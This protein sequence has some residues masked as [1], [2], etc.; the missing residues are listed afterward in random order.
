VLM[1]S[2][3][4]RIPRLFRNDFEV[5]KSKVEISTTPACS[6]RLTSRLGQQQQQENS[7]PVK[8][9]TSAGFNVNPQ[10][11]IIQDKDER[12]WFQFPVVS[13]SLAALLIYFTV[14]REENDVDLA[15]SGRLYDKVDGLEKQDLLNSI[16]YNERHG[17]DSTKLKERLR[18]VLDEEEKAKM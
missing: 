7:G 15:L 9:T 14:L 1:L 4:R 6:A 11:S 17:M 16:S 5:L 10:Q 12:P 18:E 8:F 2:S 13:G 3:Y